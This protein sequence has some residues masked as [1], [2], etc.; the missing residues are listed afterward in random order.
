[1]RARARTLGL[2]RGALT[3]IGGRRRPN[4]GAA[5]CTEGGV[6]DKGSPAASAEFRSVRHVEPLPERE[7]P[8]PGPRSAIRMQDFSQTALTIRSRP[9]A[10]VLT[11]L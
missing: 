4:S 3:A 11:Q 7:H 5:S 1:M 9:H 10:T 2:A 8:G 6:L